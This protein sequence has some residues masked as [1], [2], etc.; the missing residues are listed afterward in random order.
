MSADDLDPVIHA[1]ARLR[2]MVTLAGL[3]PGDTIT[4]SRLQQILDLTAGNLT[5]HLRRLE[6][7]GYATTDS[8]GNGRAA[9]TSIALTATGRM[10][11]SAYVKNVRSLF[12]TL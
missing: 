1:A 12:E 10:A 3:A 2:M 5:T 11:L 6:D 4:F 7:A 8:V 9:R